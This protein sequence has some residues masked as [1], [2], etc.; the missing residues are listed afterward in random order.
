[1]NKK[2]NII[3][4]KRGEIYYITNKNID[5]SEQAGKRPAVIISNNLNNRFATIVEVVF[6]TTKNKKNLPTHVKISGT[7]QPSYALCEQITTMSKSKIGKYITTIQDEEM[8]EIEKAIAISLGIRRN[9][10]WN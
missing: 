2:T 5:G 10:K 4:V 9:K 1:M 7:K 8:K 6:L 3:S